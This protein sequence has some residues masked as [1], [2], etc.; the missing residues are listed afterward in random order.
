MDGQDWDSDPFRVERKDGRLYGRGTCDMKSFIAI[1]LAFAP[2]FL[3]RGLK[4]PIH[5]AFSYD[6]E[7]GCIGVRRLIEVMNGMAVK[8][9]LCIVG[10]PTDMRVIIAHKGK[11]SYRC[12]VRGFEAHSSLA[13]DGVNAIEFAAELIAHMKAMARRIAKEGPFDPLFDIPHTTIHTGTIHGGTVI[14]IVP[15]ECHFEFEIR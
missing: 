6:E 14:N 7:I 4:T 2:K 12:H 1:A 5:L 9:K 8:P 11:T 15:K 10:E 3:E 13:P